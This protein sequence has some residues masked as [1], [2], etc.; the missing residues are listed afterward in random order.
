MRTVITYSDHKTNFWNSVIFQSIK[1]FSL[2]A[3][4]ITNV[5]NLNFF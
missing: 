2:E 3:N 1:Y 5:N 4:K